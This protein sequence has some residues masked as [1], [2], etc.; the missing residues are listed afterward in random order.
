M[1]APPRPP[2]KWRRSLYAC[3]T[4]V[5]AAIRY[6]HYS[7][8]TK[9]ACVEWAR[10]FIRFHGRRHPREIGAHEVVAYLTH[11]AT[12]RIAPLKVQTGLAGPDDAPRDLVAP[13]PRS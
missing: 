3:S 2:P 13:A 4:E 1:V 12:E 11:L 8:R 7:Y 5:R 10:R 6:R 9:E